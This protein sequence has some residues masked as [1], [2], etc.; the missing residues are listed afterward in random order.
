[1]NIPD[2]LPEIKTDRLFLRA[3]SLK[4]APAVHD[5]LQ[6][7][8]IHATTAVPYPYEKGM[9]EEWIT[10]HESA[11]KDN[12]ILRWAITLKDN[13]KLL[14]TVVLRI[15][16]HNLKGNVGYWLGHPFWGHGYTTEA[17]KAII[18]WAFKNTPIVR[19]EGDSFTENPASIAVL[20]KAGMTYEGT[21]RCSV[22]K[23][24]KLLDMAFYSILRT[25]FEGCN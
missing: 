4:D 16:P 10:G 20:K 13:D 15:E 23:D 21:Q 3:F 7:P 8:A 24:A 22:R 18:A 12:T 11:C 25:E 19:I 9:A 5:L 6:N 17:L 1:M 2:P 14:G